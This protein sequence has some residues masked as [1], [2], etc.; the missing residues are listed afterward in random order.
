MSVWG[1]IHLANLEDWVCSVL[2]PHKDKESS[3]V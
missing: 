2:Y 3:L 1:K